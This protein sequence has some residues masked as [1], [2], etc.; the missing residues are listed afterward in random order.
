MIKVLFIFGTRPEA[1]KLAPVIKRLR[2]NNSF[3]VEVCV[4]A[5]HREMLDQVLEFFNISADYDLNIMTDNQSL[6]DITASCV[7]KLEPVLRNSN[8]DL[9]IVQ[10]DTTTAFISALAG[11]YLKKRVAH[12]EAGLRSFN[13]YSPFPEEINRVLISHLAD[14]HFA[15][16][17]KAKENLLREG[18]KDN[19][20]IVGNT[21]IDALFMAVD[22]VRNDKSKKYYTYFRQIDLN[23]K[24]ILVT[25][26]RRESFGEPFKN[27]CYALKE[28]ASNF[29]DIVEI[30]YP[31]HLNPNVR[32]PVFEILN[33]IKNIYLIEPLSYD[34]LVWLMDKSYLIL[35]D[36]GGIQEEAPSLNKPVL[37]MRD[38]TERTEGIEAGTAKLVGTDKSVI[39]D[40]VSKLLFDENLY[41]SMSVAE[42]PYG[43]GKSS[44]KIEKIILETMWNC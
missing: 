22:I 19:I 23:K 26:H 27:I 16:T 32:K 36:S 12:V 28:I 17:K 11:F 2:D 13:K 43:D 7:K 34:Y 8:P 25:G 44:E 6:F 29:Y 10:G 38:V 18:I 24:L 14:I 39:V 1:I 15:P 37:V 31:V 41:K 9:L 5:Q 35:T 20:Y 3:K 4:T 30:V 33:G 21:V 40:T 42:N